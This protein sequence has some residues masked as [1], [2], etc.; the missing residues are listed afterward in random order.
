[1]NDVIGNAMPDYKLEIL[2]I[3]RLLTPK[4]RADLRAWVHLAYMAEN[5]ARKTLGLI[6]PANN[7]LSLKIQEYSCK[8]SI[9]RRKK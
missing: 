5:S 2:R 1:M 8:N 4:H 7:T 6:N 3:S 9:E